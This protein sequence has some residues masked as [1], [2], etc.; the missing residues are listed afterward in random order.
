MSIAGISGST[1]AARPSNADH[2]IGL[3]AKLEGAGAFALVGGLG[4]AGF[5]A[6]GAVRDTQM[7][8]LG[9]G[10]AALGAGLIGAGLLLG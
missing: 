2:Q 9:L 3:D 7:L 8:H 6:L 4:V 5:G 10:G 1:A